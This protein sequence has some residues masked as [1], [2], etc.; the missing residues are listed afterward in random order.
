MLLKHL[1]FGLTLLFLA[2]T[3]AAGDLAR[4]PGLE[5]DIRFWTQIFT[6][7]TSQQVLIHDNRRL[8]IVYARLDLPRSGADRTKRNFM[9]RTR[10]KY[11][12]ILGTLADGKRDGLTTEEA[13]VLSLWSEDVDNEEL[14][15]AAGRVRAQQ[16]LADGFQKGLTRSTRWEDYILHSLDAAGGTRGAGRTAAC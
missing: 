15:R 12:A 8:D 3:S 4:P 6:E 14:Q 1:V 7:V 10:K 13:R 5:P 16:G 11:K 9:D 2:L